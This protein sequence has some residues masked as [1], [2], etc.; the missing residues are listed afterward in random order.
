M[1]NFP[2]VF[3]LV[4]IMLVAEDPP[5]GEYLHHRNRQILP[6]RKFLHR[7]RCQTS[8]NALCPPTLGGVDV[9]VPIPGPQH[10]PYKF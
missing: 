10:F 3:Q 6:I 2:K 7:A 8:V 9:L 4:G 1:E 5:W